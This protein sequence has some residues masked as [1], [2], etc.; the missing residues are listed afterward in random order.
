MFINWQAR[1]HQSDVRRKPCNQIPPPQA[2]ILQSDPPP[3]AKKVPLYLVLKGSK[4]FSAEK[5][6]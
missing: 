5:H 1:M 4:N 6:P 2:K 3:H